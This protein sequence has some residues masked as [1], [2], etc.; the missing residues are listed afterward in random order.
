M[1]LARLKHVLALALA[2]SSLMIAGCTTQSAPAPES[3]KQAALQ[4]YHLDSG[5]RLRINVF[6]Q[7]ALSNTYTVDQAGYIAFPLIGQVAARGQTLTG[8][9]AR[10]PLVSSAAICAI[11]T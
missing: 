1:Q 2:G 5:D 11:R 4:P 6:E 8:L 9:E 7:T 3:F 10:L